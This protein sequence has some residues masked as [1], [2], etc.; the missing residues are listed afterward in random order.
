MK[1]IKYLIITIVM[2]SFIT[3]VFITSLPM[4]VFNI[5]FSKKYNTGILI[6]EGWGFFTKNPREKIIT[7]YEIRNNDTISLTYKNAS[8]KNYFGLSKKNRRINLESNILIAQANKSLI[9]YNKSQKNPKFIKIKRTKRILFIPSGN[10]VIIEKEILP[11]SFV[12]YKEY[13]KNE[14]KIAYISIE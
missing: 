6:P 3:I 2:L 14:Y 9:W 8:S 13:Y 1:L 5:S 12:K 11:W 4:S 7:M 10:Y